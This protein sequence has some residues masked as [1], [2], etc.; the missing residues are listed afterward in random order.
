MTITFEAAPRLAQVATTTRSG[1]TAK[2]QAAVC[3]AVRHQV[4]ASSVQFRHATPFSPLRLRLRAQLAE[5]RAVLAEGD[6]T[7]ANAATVVEVLTG[8]I[9]RLGEQR[10]HCDNPAFAQGLRAEQATLDAI[11]DQLGAHFGR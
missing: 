5:L 11:V 6:V 10:R 9:E 3:A 8:R 4:G 1:L 2:Q 7:P